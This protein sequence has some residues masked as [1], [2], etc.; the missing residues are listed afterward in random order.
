MSLYQPVDLPDSTYYKELVRLGHLKKGKT[1]AEQKAAA[2][3]SYQAYSGLEVD[4]VM[5]ERTK[6]ALFYRTDADKNPRICDCPDIIVASSVEE[7]NI[8]NGTR[9]IP[10]PEEPF[11]FGFQFNSLQ[12]VG[13]R[14]IEAAEVAFADLNAGMGVNFKVGNPN[15]CHV[16]VTKERLRGS[17]L[18]LALLS[19]GTRQLGK[20]Y[21]KY[22]SDREWYFDMLV[23][24]MIHECLHTAG[25]SHSNRRDSILW[26]SFNR[27]VLRMTAYDKERMQRSYPLFAPPEP[28][29]PKPE[30]PPIPTP[31]P[32]TDDIIITSAVGNSNGRQCRIEQRIVF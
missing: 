3:A 26:P 10:Q 4:S 7:A 1:T 11:T 5:G 28:P 12:G 13:T 20:H 17:T 9:T 23:A 16:R 8:P 6:E 22:D 15:S 18:A 25:F 32:P 31:N 29:K 27:N 21:Q 19:L 14:I 24:V 30:P 2:V